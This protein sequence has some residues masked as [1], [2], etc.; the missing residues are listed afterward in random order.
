MSSSS[1][2]PGNRRWRRRRL[3]ADHPPSSCPGAAS[4]GRT[5]TT[6]PHQ[7]YSID[8]TQGTEEDSHRKRIKTEDKAKVVAAVWGTAQ[9][10]FLAAPTILHQD[11]I[12]KGMNSSY[13]AYNP[14]T[15]HP[16]LHIVLEQIIL[17]FKSSKC[18]IASTARIWIFYASQEAATTF[19]F[20]SVFILLLCVR[21]KSV[22]HWVMEKAEK[23]P[24]LNVLQ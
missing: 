21:R 1:G 6:T 24:H 10:Q 2:A 18:K 16:I 15:M 17:F 14:G 12:N 3:W 13:S 7:Q 5:C 23:N 20:S 19:A 9:I 8:T 22:Y 4:G 11:D